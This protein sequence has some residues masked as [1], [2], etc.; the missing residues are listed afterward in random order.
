M[1]LDTIDDKTTHTGV[2]LWAHI[3]PESSRRLLLAALDAFSVHGFEG[4][5]TRDIATRAGMSPAAVYVHYRSKI[6]LLDE[7]ARIAH[8]ALWTA[9]ND[10]LAGIQTPTERLRVFMETFVRF[11][12]ESHTLARV[13]QYELKSL[14]KER[15]S[16]IGALRRRFEDLVRDELRDGVQAGEF[17][18]ADLRGTT[19]AILSLGIDVAR[20]Y[21]PGSRGT[22]SE[23][24]QLYADLTFRMVRRH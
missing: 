11:H 20:W 22:A 21:T 15:Y 6:E 12:A 8:E 13:A 2:G 9:V 14:S 5:T 10:A 16:L 4:A 23:I 24:A 7:I 17:E 19:L 3:Q 1:R 18:V